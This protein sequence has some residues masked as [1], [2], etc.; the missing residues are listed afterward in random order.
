[1]FA[2][3]CY[4]MIGELLSS[5]WAARLA[6]DDAAEVLHNKVCGLFSLLHKSL[7]HTATT[8]YNIAHNTGKH[9]HVFSFVAFNLSWAP[10]AFAH[11][12]ITATTKPA[13]NIILFAEPA[14]PARGGGRAHR[15]CHSTRAAAL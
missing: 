6:R 10:N 5:M 11:V 13:H 14:S 9:T 15:P 12:L 1:M 3:D 7:K 4:V 2:Q 8:T